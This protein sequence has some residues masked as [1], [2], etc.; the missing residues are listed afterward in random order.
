MM[1]TT[2]GI[3]PVQRSRRVGT[4]GKSE[5]VYAPIGTGM[6]S[7]A[8]GLACASS[9]ILTMSTFYFLFYFNDF[10]PRIPNH[11]SL[12]VEGIAPPILSES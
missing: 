12:W 10:T 5:R 1:C 2:K 11:L 3:I 8:G 7:G 9:C 6:S 4:I